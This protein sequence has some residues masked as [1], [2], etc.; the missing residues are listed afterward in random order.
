M[1]SMSFSVATG[2]RL[3]S[4]ASCSDC[5]KSGIVAAITVGDATASYC[6]RCWPAA[7]ERELED[8]RRAL[9]EFRKRWRANPSTASLPPGRGMTWTWSV[10]IATD[11]RHLR[12]W[13]ENRGDGAD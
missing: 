13:L 4:A 9:A 2:P 7:H 1:V 5:G 10:A 11:L 12:S 8:R 6:R 3:D